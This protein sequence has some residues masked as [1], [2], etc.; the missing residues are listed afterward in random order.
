MCCRKKV[1]QKLAAVKKI[2]ITVECLD[3]G[4]L[5]IYIYM[6]NVCVSFYN[7]NTGKEAKYQHSAFNLG[8]G[9]IV[10]TIC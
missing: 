3:N 2:T 4:F 8:S 6:L 10:T 5:S 1:K 9:N 7:L